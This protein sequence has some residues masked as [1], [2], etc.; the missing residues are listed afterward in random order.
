M[1][2]RG[3]HENFTSTDHG[4][5]TDAG[6]LRTDDRCGGNNHASAAD[7]CLTPIHYATW[8]RKVD[9]ALLRIEIGRRN[10]LNATPRDDGWE[11][12]DDIAV[13]IDTC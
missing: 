12:R 5:R 3:I 4:R 7:P 9:V 10:S 8:G 11:N 6:I 13:F 2:G 1:A